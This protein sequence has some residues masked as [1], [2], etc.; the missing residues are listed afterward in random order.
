M[1]INF[2][3]ANDQGLSIVFNKVSYLLNGCILGKARQCRPFE[4]NALL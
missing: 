3:I 1:I 2:L 4:Y